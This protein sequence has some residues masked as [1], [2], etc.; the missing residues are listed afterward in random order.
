[1][2]S[3]LVFVLLQL[4]DFGTTIAAISLGAV[5]EN[6]IVGHLMGLGLY[7]GL[8]AAKLLALGI[9][10]FAAASGRYGGLRKA[11]IAFAVIVLWNLGTI[12]RL[13]K[14]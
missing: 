6:P 1:M 2:K 4:A 8:V 7:T 9:G 11:N 5:E 10:G 13:M 3:L 14:A 12:G